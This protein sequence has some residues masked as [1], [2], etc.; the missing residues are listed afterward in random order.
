MSLILAICVDTR[1]AESKT[2]FVQPGSNGLLDTILKANSFMK[3]VKQT[4]DATLDSRLLVETADLSYKKTANLNLGN[5]IESVDVEE[6][7]SKCISFMR[8]GSGSV[9]LHGARDRD[10]LEDDD[11]NAMDW[12]RLGHHAAFPR[13]SRPPVPGFL[14]GPLSVQKRA[15]IPRGKR[16]SQ[17]QTQ[18]QIIRPEE[19][20]ASDLEKKDNNNLTA[21]CAKI[22]NT[23]ATVSREGEEAV[24]REHRPDMSPA[25]TKALMKRHNIAD[26]GGINFFRFAI[27][28]R[29]F[30]QTVENL[31][32]IS[33][34]I[35]EA[36]VALAEDETGLPT[37]RLWSQI[38]A[39]PS[40]C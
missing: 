1:T 20:K 14:L 29:S 4:S 35:R 24:E 11:G 12:A 25:E 32:Y 21:L 2:D 36:G 15:R 17:R 31:F 40:R 3:E 6:F 39:Y 19:L 13:N 7:V 8:T 30:G 23:L 37:L 5:A 33:F 9:Q 34:L 27:N 22:R 16:A 38:L 18:T 26:N 28:P 10:D